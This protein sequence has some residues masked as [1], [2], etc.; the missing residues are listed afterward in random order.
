MPTY[1][2]ETKASE[3]KG[4]VQVT[5][6]PNGS[7]DLNTGRVDPEPMPST[8]LSPEK[9]RRYVK[10]VTI[11]KYSTKDIRST[12]KFNINTLKQLYNVAPTTESDPPRDVDYAHGCVCYSAGAGTSVAAKS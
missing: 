9:V 6:L 5:Q 8:T 11:I 12:S 3:S 10:C 7:Q 4:L 2:E 1:K